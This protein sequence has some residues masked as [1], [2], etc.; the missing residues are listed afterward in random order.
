MHEE[1]RIPRSLKGPVVLRQWYVERGSHVSCGDRVFE[2]EAAIGYV[3]V[4]AQGNG[5]VDPVV[6]SGSVLGPGDLVGVFQRR[7]KEGHHW[8]CLYPSRLA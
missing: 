1:I 4:V 3:D 5:I 8:L 7:P 6:N 2:I